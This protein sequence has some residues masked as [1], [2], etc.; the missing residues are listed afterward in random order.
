[1]RIT[2]RQL[3]RVIKEEIQRIAEA[4]FDPKATVFVPPVKKNKPPLQDVDSSAIIASFEKG[5]KTLTT[6]AADL[7]VNDIRKI[8]SDLLA[9]AG[10]E[11]D[12]TG[13]NLQATKDKKTSTTLPPVGPPI[14]KSKRAVV[15]IPPIKR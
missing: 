2:V 4:G 14:Q 12:P 5:N 10:L 8:T 13:V 1:M 15:I 3:R 6:L 9:A 7:G 11:V